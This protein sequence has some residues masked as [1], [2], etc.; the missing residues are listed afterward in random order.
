MFHQITGVS[1]QEQVSGTTKVF[2]IKNDNGTHS[3]YLLCPGLRKVTAVRVG[4]TNLPLTR[5]IEVPV[6]GQQ[7]KTV[8]QTVP[9]VT[10]AH[11]EAGCPVLLRSTLSHDGYWQHGESIYVTGEWVDAEEDTIEEINE[12]TINNMGVP[13]MSALFGP[14]AATILVGET[15]KELSEKAQAQIEADLKDPNNVTTTAMAVAGK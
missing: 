6:Y 1:R 10:I 13:H 8:T 9:M 11:D 3:P 2:R 4:N 5:D 14:G 12:E 15:G 7:G